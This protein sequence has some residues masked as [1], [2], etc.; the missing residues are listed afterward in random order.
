MKKVLL[1]A[2]L[3]LGSLGAIAQ[4]KTTETVDI[5]LDKYCCKSLNPI[6]EKTL[7]YE[8]GVKSF[9]INPENKTV[10]VKYNTKRTNPDKIAKAL[11]KEGVMANGIEATPK[12]I[13]RLPECCKGVAKG[14]GEGCGEH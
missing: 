13:E 3:I 8:R 14:I 11:A 12:A 2:F 10:K 7:A 4:N 1:L 9:E 5:K 6:V